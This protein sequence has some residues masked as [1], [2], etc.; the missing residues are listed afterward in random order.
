MK[1]R[2]HL[3]ERQLAVEQAKVVSLQNKLQR[4]Q[5]LNQDHE[6]AWR[7]RSYFLGSPEAWSQFYE[8]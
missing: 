7:N 2:M 8:R 3:A 5:E 1:S 4:A 6:N